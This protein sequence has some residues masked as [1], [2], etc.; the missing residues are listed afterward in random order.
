MK[1]FLNPWVS[2]INGNRPCGKSLYDF[3]RRIARGRRIFTGNHKLILLL[4][5][6]LVRHSLWKTN[7][8]SIPASRIHPLVFGQRMKQSVTEI[9][10]SGSIRH[11]HTA[12]FPLRHTRNYFQMSAGC[13][14]QICP[15]LFTC[16][17]IRYPQIAVFECQIRIPH[18][19]VRK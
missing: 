9:I 1:F 4:K 5:R 19:I 11:Y 3:F 12:E 7:V 2:P 16:H 14:F 18:R 6:Q 17:V 15:V 8:I 10:P 13:Q